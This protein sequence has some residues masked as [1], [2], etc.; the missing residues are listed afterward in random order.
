M[1]RRSLILATL[2]LAGCTKVPAGYQGVMVNLYGSDKG[3]SDQLYGV[4]RYYLGWNSEMYL[5]PT[6]LQNY[7]W[8]DNSNGGQDIGNDESITM[9]TSEGLSINTDVGITYQIQPD[10][11]VKVFQH[12]RLGVDE[13]T[14][15]FLR[16]MVR[17]AM[18]QVASTMTIDELYGLQKEKFIG[19]VNNLVKAQAANSGIDV[20]KVYL[21]GTFR[22]PQT[23]IDS[24]NS[25][26]QATQNAM[27]AENE[28]ALAQAEAQKLLV[29]A[30]AQAKANQMIEASLTP[31]YVQ[32]LGVTRWDGHLPKVTGSATP[33]V[34]IGNEKPN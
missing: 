32:Y 2:L 11:V 6:F 1:N 9:Q 26:I 4:G 12:Y 20:D 16:N 31:E 7:T 34:D 30:A 17:D 18:N 33:F 15:T 5:F 14:N 3:V 27:R 23:V 21:I 28:V 29:T 22:L 19:E 8:M 13:I 25:K 24:I 10:N